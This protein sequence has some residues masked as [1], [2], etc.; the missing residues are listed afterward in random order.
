MAASAARANGRGSKS[1]TE[2][3]FDEDFYVEGGLVVMTAAYHLKRGKCCGNGCR[4]CPYEP[5]HQPGATDI[6]ASAHPARANDGA[7]GGGVFGA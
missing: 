5:Q 3:V 6:A 1:L 2:L 4:W 7:G